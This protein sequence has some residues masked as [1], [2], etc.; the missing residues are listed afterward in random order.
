MTNEIYLPAL[1]KS[2]RLCPRNQQEDSLSRSLDFR[3]ETCL[4]LASSYSSIACS[5]SEAVDGADDVLKVE[6][7]PRR[8][9]TRQNQRY[10]GRSLGCA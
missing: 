2:R 8:N 4:S 3:T 5:G 1:G 10:A 9:N 6:S 7:T